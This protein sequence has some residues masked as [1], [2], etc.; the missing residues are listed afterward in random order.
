M[1]TLVFRALPVLAMGLAMA[2]TAQEAPPDPGAQV[3][4]RVGDETITAADFAREVRFRLREVQIATGRAAKPDSRMRRV[5]MEELINGHVLS[6]AARNAGVEVSGEEVEK[7]F[8]ERK[9]D[10]KTDQAYQDYLKFLGMTE[11][12]LKENMLSRIRVTKFVDGQ[13]GEITATEED[14]QE[15]YKAL[16]ERGVMTRKEKT[17]D[18]GMILIR[19]DG[20]SDEAWRA[21]EDEAGKVH[22]R[23][24]QGEEFEALAKEV[25]DEPLSASRGGV[26]REMKFGAF[27]PELE[28]VMDKLEPGTYSKP[29]RGVSGW[30][31]V[32]V[33]S[34]N[35]PGTILL[36]EVREGVEREFVDSVRKK[37]IA[38]IVA[39]TRTLLRIELAEAPEDD[40]DGGEA[41]VEKGESDASQ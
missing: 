15:T 2:A 22:G 30:Y 10:F 26:M 6:V 17:R 12:A 39:E 21:A 20:E 4:A 34:V 27:H 28:E 33:F 35:D 36:D 24:E 19:P 8:E 37:K 25:S 11:E 38:E 16:Q 9:A 7:Q 29:V 1:S 40:G 23:L 32:K 13:V 3:L 31:I 18:V 5:V 41:P 14:L